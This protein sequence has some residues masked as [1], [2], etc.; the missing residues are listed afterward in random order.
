MEYVRNAFGVKVAPDDR[1]MLAPKENECITA[2]AEFVQLVNPSKSLLVDVGAYHGKWSLPLSAEFDKVVAIEPVKDNAKVLR[3][4]A[5]ANRIRNVSVIT[6]AL[7]EREGK[8]R[9]KVNGAWSA[10]SDDGE[11]VRMTT[12]DRVLEKYNAEEY[13]LVVVKIDT[14][15]YEYKILEGAEKAISSDNVVFVIEHHE[16]WAGN[17]P[18]THVDIARKLVFADRLP[19]AICDV[20]WAYVPKKFDRQAF[21]VFLGRHLFYVKMV[22]NLRRGLPWYFGIPHD[23]WHGCSILDF[24]F[25]VRDIVREGKMKEYE[26]DRAYVDSLYEF[27]NLEVSV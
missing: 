17:E 12:L 22:R 2:V 14:E 11:E 15:G 24:V 7:G 16:Y 20:H 25:A 1:E 26:L 21:E 27:L 5:R 23:W 13:E 19:F 8:A 6:V 4:Y 9:I 10:I 18:A 3:A